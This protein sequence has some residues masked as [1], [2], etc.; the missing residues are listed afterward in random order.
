M[1]AYRA[2]TIQNNKVGAGDLKSDHPKSNI[3]TM[4]S[5]VHGQIP[6]ACKF[7]PDKFSFR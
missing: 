7:F 1:I 3:V 2:V 6:T 4:K 5:N